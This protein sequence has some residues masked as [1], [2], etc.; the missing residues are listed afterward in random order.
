MSVPGQRS[1]AQYR[2]LENDSDLTAGANDSLIFTRFGGLSDYAANAAT[3]DL[4][5]NSMGL[6]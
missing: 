5:S 2:C 1:T 3:A 6:A 4:N